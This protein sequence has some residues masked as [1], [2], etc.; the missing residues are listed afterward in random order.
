MKIAVLGLC[1]AIAA[2][3]GT[4][5]A[6]TIQNARETLVGNNNAVTGACSN[7][8]LPITCQF[9]EG[10]GFAC[11]GPAGSYSGSD[12]NTLIFSACG[13]SVQ[14]EREKGQKKQIE[15]VK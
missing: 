10:T 11:D 4:A 13:C 9:K 2:L 6:C 3:E 1:I 15:K 5:L 12:L 8:G 7:N 14:D